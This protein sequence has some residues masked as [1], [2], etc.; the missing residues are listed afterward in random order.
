MTSAVVIGNLTFEEIPAKGESSPH[1]QGTSSVS[2]FLEKK[3]E[4]DIS[5]PI[6]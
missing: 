4:E 2:V 1:N 3:M 5:K 6:F